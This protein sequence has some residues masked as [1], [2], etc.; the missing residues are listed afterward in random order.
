M[1]F[2]YFRM[3][4]WFFMVF[5]MLII[6]FLLTSYKLKLCY[7]LASFGTLKKGAARGPSK[8]KPA[9]IFVLVI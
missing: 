3:L 2:P 1:L 8:Q 7:K 5:E 6:N 9:P 4:F